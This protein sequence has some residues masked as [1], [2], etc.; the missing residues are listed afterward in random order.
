MNYHFKNSK[1]SKQCEAA[2]VEKYVSVLVCM[3]E[4]RIQLWK[5][6]SY[7]RVMRMEREAGRNEQW[8]RAGQHVT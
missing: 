1:N 6:R 8:T 3:Q 4:E 2:A 5:D 7:E